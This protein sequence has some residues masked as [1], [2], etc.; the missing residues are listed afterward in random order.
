[1]A[2]K[3]NDDVYDTLAVYLNESCVFLYGDDSPGAVPPYLAFQSS[4]E[5]LQSE[6]TIGSGKSKVATF[7]G[8]DT[9]P[10]R[11]VII[12]GPDQYPSRGW[13]S[14]PITLP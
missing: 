12:P 10:Y 8:F 2:R 3:L 7:P 13:L 9:S 14:G 6:G 4:G 5:Y 11:L 1:M